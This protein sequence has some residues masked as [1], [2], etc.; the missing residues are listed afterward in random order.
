MNVIKE[1][2]TNKLLR[3][4]KQKKVIVTAG[5][6]L[7]QQEKVDLFG[8]DRTLFEEIIVTKKG[9]KGKEYQRLQ[10]RFG[11]FLVIGDRLAD[12]LSE[13]KKL[14]GI[15]IHIRQGRG[16][17]EPKNH[18]DV[19]YEIATIHELKGVLEKI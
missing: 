14:G 12:D 1:Y 15:T 2:E 4:L 17:L 8:I 3:E 11:K 9:E 13:A 19:D 10:K 18:P 7:V 16:K 6:V 5:N